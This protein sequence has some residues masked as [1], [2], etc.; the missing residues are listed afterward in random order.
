[1][2]KV[3]FI[4]ICRYRPIMKKRLSVSIGCSLPAGTIRDME[5]WKAIFVSFR[6]IKSAYP[7]S[8]AKAHYSD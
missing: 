3:A 2:Y 6:V 4:S 5:K 7:N 1:M 8:L